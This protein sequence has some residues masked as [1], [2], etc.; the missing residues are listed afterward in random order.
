VVERR[1]ALTAAFVGTDVPSST[2]AAVEV[3]VTAAFWMHCSAQPPPAPRIG[4]SADAEAV[5][6]KC[7]RQRGGGFLT[8]R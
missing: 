6:A 1:R 3:V 8:E 4:P 5:P 2:L 7:G